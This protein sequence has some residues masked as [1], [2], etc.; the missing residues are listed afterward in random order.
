MGFTIETGKDAPG[1]SLPGVDGKTLSLDDYADQAAVVVVFTCNHCP[2]AIDYEDRLIQ[3]QDDYAAKGVQVIAINSNETDGHPT[4]SLS[5]MIERAEEKGFNFP[6]LRDESQDVAKAYGAMRTPHVFLL[7][8]DRK[9]VYNGR[10]DD[11]PDDPNN[12]GRHDLREAIDETLAGKP[13]SVPV[14]QSIGCNVKWWGRD[15]H[16]MPRDRGDF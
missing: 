10:V 9:V 14:T 4:D 1:F 6:Y 2:T 7:D 11:M 8:A 16:W 15:A 13:V 3:I 5:H 12:V